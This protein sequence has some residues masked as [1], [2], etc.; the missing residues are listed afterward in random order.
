MSNFYDNIMDRLMKEQ[1]TDEEHQI[2]EKFRD[3]FQ[4]ELEDK[5]FVI[6]LDNV[7]SDIGF[8]L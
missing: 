1:L 4:K 7:L 3:L 5:G 6:D 8:T 2:F